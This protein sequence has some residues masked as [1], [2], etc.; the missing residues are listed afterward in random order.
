MIRSS[1]LCI[2]L[3]LL[4][5]VIA[6]PAAGSPLDALRADGLYAWQVDA[7]PDAPAWC[8]FRFRGER[9]VFDAC[10]LDGGLVN[11][12]LDGGAGNGGTMQLYAR[13][14]AG[15]LT[16]L[17]ALG[18]DCPVRTRQPI[19][20]LGRIDG[21]ASVAWLARELERGSPVESDLLAAIGVHAVDPARAVLLEATR[22]DRPEQRRKD[23]IFWL[24]QLRVAEVAREME[25][26]LFD[27]PDPDIREQAAFA[28]SQS[29]SAERVDLLS[30]Q[31]RD[32]RNPSVRGQAWFWLAQTGAPD[33]AERIRSAIA[34][35]REVREEAVFALSQLPDEQ[36]VGALLATLEDPR[37]DDDTRRQALF[38]LT[39]SDSERAWAYLD[40]LL[41]PGE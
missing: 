11:H 39:Q 38:W 28:L 17:R 35:D 14:E 16:R 5:A 33:A 24:G 8:C 27:D 12:G 40:R 34:S 3:P 37:L 36:A 19:I 9:P 26:W 13:I 30:R 1:R 22:P 4:A 32:D 7:L 18:A 25:H 2:A 23:A 31:G 15:T 10:N 21:D 29:D 20:D 41:A 6:A